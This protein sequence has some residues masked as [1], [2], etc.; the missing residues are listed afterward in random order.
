MERAGVR[1]RTDAHNMVF[2]NQSFDEIERLVKQNF[3]VVKDYYAARTEALVDIKDVYE[4][5]L[6]VVLHY[7]FTCNRWRT[8]YKLQQNYDL[9]FKE[10]DFEEPATHD[11]VIAYFKRKYAVLDHIERARRLLGLTVQEFKAYEKRREYETED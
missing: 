10:T 2:E 11:I 8:L 3:E 5:S 9:S 6:R 7:L 4:L 1:L